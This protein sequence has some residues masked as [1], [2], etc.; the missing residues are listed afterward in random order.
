[1]FTEKEEKKNNLFSKSAFF[2]VCAAG[3]EKLAKYTD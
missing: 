2:Q 3:G 1:M